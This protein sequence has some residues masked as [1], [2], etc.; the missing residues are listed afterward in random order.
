MG[1]PLALTATWPFAIFRRMGL[2]AVKHLASLSADGIRRLRERHQS[3]VDRSG[4]PESCWPWMAQRKEGYGVV[5][6]RR[7]G[8]WRWVG[9]AHQ[10]AVAFDSPIPDGQCVLH[11]CDNP[12]CCNPAHLFLGTQVENIHDMCRKGRDRHLRGRENYPGMHPEHAQGERNGNA[13]LT[14]EKVA[15]IRRRAAAGETKAALSREFGVSDVHVGCIVSG[16]A[17]RA[18]SP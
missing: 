9:Y 11:R 16:K 10:F 4:G 5:Y 15:E 2:A 1:R 13:K 6:G 18:V 12:P 3:H 7:D 8:R 17:W 14:A